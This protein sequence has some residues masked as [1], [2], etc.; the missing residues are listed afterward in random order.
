MAKHKNEVAQILAEKEDLEA[1]LNSLKSGSSS[2]PPST[3]SAAQTPSRKAAASSV[4]FDKYK[5]RLLEN[6]GKQ[7]GLYRD[8]V[9]QLT[10][11]KVDLAVDQAKPTVKI[12]SMYAE[13]EDD[14]LNFMKNDTGSFDLLTSR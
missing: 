14:C 6:F 5:K 7:T 8:S 9:Y 2:I 13:K 11:F 12:R 3:P 1:E 10:G 4:D